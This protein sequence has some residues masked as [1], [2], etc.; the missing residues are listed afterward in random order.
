MV[1][2]LFSSTGNAGKGLFL[3]HLGGMIW[4]GWLQMSV[5][6]KANT[7]IRQSLNRNKPSTG[8]I[9]FTQAWT[10]EEGVILSKIPLLIK[11]LF[12]CCLYPVWVHLK[13]IFSIQCSQ[14]SC[15]SRQTPISDEIS[16]LSILNTNQ[17]PW[18]EVACRSIVLI[19]YF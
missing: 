8:Q 6:S 15:F 19:V 4:L 11:L 3:L 16:N 17:K 14:M 18:N 1:H 10:G 7:H 9:T 13:I 12:L 5:G 2:L